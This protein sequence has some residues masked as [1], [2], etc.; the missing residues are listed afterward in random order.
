MTRSNVNFTAAASSGVPSWKR[1][2]RRSLNVHARPSE[3]VVHDS[4]SPGTTSVLSAAVPTSVSKIS[5]VTRKV[6]RPSPW[7]GATP[8]ASASMP[9]A[10]T[11]RGVCAVAGPASTTAASAAAT[12]ERDR[13]MAR[14][15]GREAVEEPVTTG[16][17]QVV[18]AAAAVG[19]ARGMGRVPGLGR[20][21]VPEPLTIVVADHRR[22]LTVLGPVAARA[23]LAGRERSAVRL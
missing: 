11:S 1:T 14:L 7:P 23:I 22:A 5:A 13:D 6:G 2:P 16:A 4:A 20:V 8:G 17:L 21:V 12:M 9:T 18:L 15:L 19:A 3:D 10:S